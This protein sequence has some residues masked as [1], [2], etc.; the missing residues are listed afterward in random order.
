MI[1]LDLF[2][3]FAKIGVMTFG[4][5]YA[6]L[7]IIQR[8]IVEKKK[9]VTEAEVMDY[10]AIGQCTPGVIAVNTATFTGRHIAGDLGGICATAGVVFP[11]IVIITIIAALIRGFAHIQ[12]VQDALAGIRVCV[13]VLVFNAVLKMWKKAVIDRV[14]LVLYLVI[15]IA[16]VFF[17]ASSTLVTLPDLTIKESVTIRAFSPFPL[18]CSPSSLITFSPEIIFC[19]IRNVF[20]N[21]FTL[22]SF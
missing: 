6:M 5:G 14:T 11:S 9:W 7:P 21:V 3:A 13:C 4:G 12:A 17:N 16:S 18:I 22:S 1:Y 8:E 2:L 20:P 10:Y 19:G 15:L